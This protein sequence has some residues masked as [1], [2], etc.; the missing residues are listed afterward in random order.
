MNKSNKIIL[1]TESLDSGGAE[2]QLVS[3]AVLLKESGKDVAVWTYDSRDFYLPNLLNSDI[4]YYCFAEGKNKISRILTFTKKIYEVQ[5]SVLIAYSDSPCVLSCICK[6]LLF[7]FRIDFN[8]IV[9]ERNITW[10]ISMKAKLK[11][12]LFR[13]ASNIVTNTYTQKSFIEKK[14]RNLAKKTVA[15]SNCI[16]TNFFVP[17]LKK[18]DCHDEAIRLLTVGRI[19]AQKNVKTYFCA[20]KKLVDEGYKI[21]VDWYGT[22][23]DK[24]Y[25]K[26]CVGFIDENSLEKIIFFHSPVVNIREVYYN[27]DVL[28]LPSLYEGCPNVLCEAM[29]CGLPVTCSS[30]S[31]I[32]LIVGSENASFLFNPKNVD[33]IVRSLSSLLSKDKLTLC[34]IGRKNRERIVLN[35]SK[36]FFLSRYL[37]LIE[38]QD[39]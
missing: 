27:S 33:S 10:K 14:F 36:E 1:L 12:S 34:E 16:D 35:N 19:S 13:F 5:P 26:E 24:S 3:L 23:Q 6:L 38:S 21:R 39:I 37:S 20:I 18:C 15:I 7:G 32:P 9:S 30:V 11:F 17:S 2:R 28:C 25:Y 29:A 31:D 4:P 22:I 8:L